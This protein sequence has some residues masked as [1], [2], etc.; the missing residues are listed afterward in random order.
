MM[1]P[2]YCR[3]CPAMFSGWFRWLRYAI[4]GITDHP[5]AEV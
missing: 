2:I 3:D 1:N 5:I 4:H